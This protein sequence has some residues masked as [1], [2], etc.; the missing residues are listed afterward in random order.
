MSKKEKIHKPLHVEIE[1]LL[2]ECNISLAT[3]HGGKLNG[4]DCQRFMNYA[5]TIF[6]KIHAKKPGEP[7]QEDYDILEKS[8]ANLN[9]LWTQAH[10]NFT[11]KLHSTL[12]H[13]LD[14]MGQ[15]NGIGD[16]LEDDVEHMQQIAAKMEA[17]VLVHSK[18]EPMQNSCEIREAMENSIQLSKRTFKNELQTYSK[19]N[20]AKEERESKRMEN[21][22][23]NCT[24]SGSS[25]WQ[26]QLA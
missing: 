5:T 4:V 9:Y 11:P 19:L 12:E 23:K 15:F 16:M 13:S 8:V 21:V 20:E 6:S 26:K 18:M 25:S 3:Y 7:T 2:S 10:L 17:R 24:D 1:L 14:H 22:T